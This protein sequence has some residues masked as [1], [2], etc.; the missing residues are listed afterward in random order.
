MQQSTVAKNKSHIKTDARVIV[1]SVF[2]WLCDVDFASTM[3]AQ[4]AM[5]RRAYFQTELLTK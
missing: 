3:S 2:M 4:T 5:D 1:A